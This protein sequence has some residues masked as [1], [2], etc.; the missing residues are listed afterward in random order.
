MDRYRIRNC[1]QSV[2]QW[3]MMHIMFCMYKHFLGFAE[4]YSEETKH[5]GLQRIY[6]CPVPRMMT[7]VSTQKEKVLR[8]KGG[9]KAERC[10]CSDKKQKIYRHNEVLEKEMLF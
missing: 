1:A 5:Q 9:R 10:K 2:L 3:E 7:Q 6:I 8:S 4:L